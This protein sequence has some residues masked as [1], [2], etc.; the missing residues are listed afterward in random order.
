MAGNYWMV[1]Q[2]PEDFEISRGLGFSL[3]GVPARYRRR[4]QRMQRNDRV[5]YYVTGIRKWTGTAIITSGF[6]E[7]RKPVWKPNGRGEEYPYRVKLAPD[8]VLQ[9]EDYIDALMLA[10]TL[11]YVKRWEPEDWPLA[12][13][14]RLHL[15]PQRD[16]RL[17]EGEMRRNLS[18]RRRAAPAQPPASP[19]SQPASHPG[20]NLSKEQ[21]PTDAP[22]QPAA[23]GS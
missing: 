17:I 9:E 5:L 23:D 15:L 6:F 19:E 18:K 4:A 12:F 7:D 11:E 21:A 10:P 1:V 2:S 16:F 13:Y 8:I 3:H 22:P 14:E 20:E